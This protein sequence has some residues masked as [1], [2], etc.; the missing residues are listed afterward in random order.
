MELYCR[1]CKKKTEAIDIEKKDSKTGKF[2]IGKCKV[3]GSKT[4]AKKLKKEDW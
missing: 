3:C 2:V 1:K 4:L